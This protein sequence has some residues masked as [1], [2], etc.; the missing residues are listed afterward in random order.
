MKTTSKK[1]YIIAGEPSG[2]QLG[3]YLMAALQNLRD[4]IT[5]RGIGGTH[6]QCHGLTS[7]FNMHDLSLI[8]IWEILPNIPTL[9]RHRNHAVR[10]IIAWQP[11]MIITIDSP[12]FTKQIIKKIRASC[13]KMIAIHYVAPSVWAWKE[14]RKYFYRDYYDHLLCLFDFEPRYFLDIGLQASCVGHSLIEQKNHSNL[15]LKKIKNERYILLLPGSR[16]SEIKKLLPLFLD[17]IDDM[18]SYNTDETYKFL[19][20]QAYG[21][22]NL[23]QQILSSSSLSHAITCYPQSDKITL[24]QHAD[25]AIGASG[26]VL[27]EAAFYKLPAIMC[28]KVSPI[29]AY[30]VRKLTKIKFFHIIN[31]AA[32]SYII[33]EFIQKNCDSKKIAAAAIKLLSPDARQ[34]QLDN[35][36]Q[37]ID[38]LGDNKTEKSP[39]QKAADIINGY[40]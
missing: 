23:I 13:P 12:G 6:M 24:M 39:S 36:A 27:L 14:Y 31:I 20:I 29:T 16:E 7:L 4:D 34:Q 8:G 15:I 19:L 1:I 10:D 30:I 37:Y 28:Y 25:I 22:E 33:P 26:T 18:L 9:I 2:D 40:L 38:I 5:F 32:Q 3:G 35:I 17:L 11:D 21:Q